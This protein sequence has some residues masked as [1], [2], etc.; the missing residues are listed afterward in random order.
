MEQGQLPF[1]DDEAAADLDWL[2]EWAATTRWTFAR[3]V[4]DQPHE[5][6]RADP[7]YS[8]V[9]ALIRRYG[10]SRSWPPE[11]SELHGKVRPRPYRYLDLGNGFELWVGPSNF[12]NRGR[13]GRLD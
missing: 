3:T 11:T 7:D 4:P 9:A 8:K 6:V 5:Y 10:I 1:E 13:V 2:R 12:V